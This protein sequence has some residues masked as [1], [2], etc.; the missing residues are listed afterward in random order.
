MSVSNQ[1]ADVL[2]CADLWAF[3]RLLNWIS[4]FKCFIHHHHHH[5]FLNCE[6]RW[7]IT[8]DFAT[9]FLH[10]SLS[11][12]A[13][14]DMPNSTPVHSLMLS[15][16]KTSGFISGWNL[17]RGWRK[18]I[19]ITEKLRHSPTFCCFSLDLCISD[20]KINWLILAT[21]SPEEQLQ[22]HLYTPQNLHRLL[23]HWNWDWKVMDSISGRS[24]GRIFFSRVHYLCWIIFQYPFHPS[25]TTVA[26]KIPPVI[27]PKVQMAG[28]S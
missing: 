25:V 24:G 20:R 2:C 1:T 28:Y 8:N 16:G 26:C 12:T 18:K 11:S 4:H 13:L 3:C 6:G 10:F 21:D 14:W 27:L 23:E 22:C 5:Q 7:G 19:I 17:R 15:S 9:S